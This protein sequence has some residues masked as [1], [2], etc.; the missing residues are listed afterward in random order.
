MILAERERVLCGEMPEK[1]P[2]PEWTFEPTA[3]DTVRVARLGV[4]GQTPKRWSIDFLR[5]LHF[6]NGRGE[7]VLES[8]WVPMNLTTGA[9]LQEGTGKVLKKIE[10]ASEAEL[11]VAR[12]VAANF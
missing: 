8:V 10:P 3:L 1:E 12:A 11:Q 2:K 9:A 7:L 6:R 4:P 5:Q